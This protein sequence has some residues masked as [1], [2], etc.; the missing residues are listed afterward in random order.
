VVIDQKP[1]GG[2]LLRQNDGLG[3]TR[4]K[5]GHA[6]NLGNSCSVLNVL[7]GQPSSER[8]LNV[9]ADGKPT[10]L[11]DYLAKYGGRNDH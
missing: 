2:A 9:L 6:N 4:I 8:S 1:F 5:A 11:L 3:F 7:N 10:T